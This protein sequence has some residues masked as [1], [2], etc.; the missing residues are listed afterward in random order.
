[1]DHRT[2]N[3]EAGQ[4]Q[5]K[6]FAHASMP[7]MIFDRE[8]HRCVVANDAADKAYG[9]RADQWKAVSLFDICEARS[10][11]SLEARLHD[12]G[13]ARG[14]AGHHRATQARRQQLLGRILAGANR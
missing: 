3:D 7:M 12:L 1:M 2:A 14:E 13:A 5:A 6:A 4:Q 11:A 9:Y 10:R 8:T